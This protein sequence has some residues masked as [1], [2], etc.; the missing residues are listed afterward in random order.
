VAAR[1][2]TGGGERREARGA[3]E[4][5]RREAEVVQRHGDRDVAWCLVYWGPGA[6]SSRIRVGYRVLAGCFVGKF[7]G[8]TIL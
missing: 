8:E 2:E 3:K 5:E 1:G 7:F 4:R 6:A